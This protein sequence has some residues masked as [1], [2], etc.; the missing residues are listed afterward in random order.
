M[1]KEYLE[2]Y[3]AAI[4]CLY[5][6]ANEIICLKNCNETEYEEI[7]KYD[8]EQLK[9]LYRTYQF[10][11]KFLWVSKKNINYASI[12]NLVTSG[13]LTEAEAVQALLG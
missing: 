1:W 7:K 6:D 13:V 9:K 2:K 5:E 8:I 4:I 12:F 10:S 11:D 3:N